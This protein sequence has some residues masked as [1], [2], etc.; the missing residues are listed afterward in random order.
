M[1]ALGCGHGGVI[2]IS[3]RTSSSSSLGGW[4]PDGQIF[5]F[6]AR[7]GWCP[8]L[9][10]FVPGGELGGGIEKKPFFFYPSSALCPLPQQDRGDKTAAWM[11]LYWLNNMIC[12]PPASSSPSTRTPHPW[13]GRRE[14]IRSPRTFG[15]LWWGRR[16]PRWWRG[17]SCRLRRRQRSARTRDSSLWKCNGPWNKIIK[18]YYKM[19]FITSL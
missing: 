5:K 2:C 17:R 16:S 8:A 11:I 6:R 3:V 18:S 14:C 13:T 9:K 1:A 12:L 15:C 7:L 19:L 4:Y 10:N